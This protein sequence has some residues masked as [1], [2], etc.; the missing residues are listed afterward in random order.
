MKLDKT[1]I[2]IRGMTCAACVRRVERILKSVPGV[3]DAV[4]N[5]ATSKATLSHLSSAIDLNAVSDS[6]EDAGYHFLGIVSNDSEDRAE[7]ARKEDLL[8]IRRKLIVGAILSVFIHL[9]AM[10]HM[11]P[12]SIHINPATSNFIQLLMTT[13]VV[14]WVGGR[15]LG[16]A[17][18]ALRQ[19][20]SDMNTLV[21][22]GA[23]SAYFYSLVVTLFPD[24]LSSGSIQ[25]YVYFDGAAMIVT[26]VLLGRY[27]EARAKGKTS[28]AIRKLIKLKPS[29]A[30]V[31]RN[32]EIVDVPIELL[33]EGDL[34]QVRPGERIPTDGEIVSGQSSVDEAM[35]T[36]ESMPV[37]KNIGDQ[38]YGAT[39]NQNGSLTVRATRVGSETALAKVIRL[40][41][42]AQGSKAPIQRIADRVAAVFV[43]VV[44]VIALITFFIWFYLPSDP[45]ISR[46]MLNFVSVLIIAC[47][48]AMGLATPTAVMVGTGAAAERGILIK[49]GE[50]LEMA[51]KINTV[52]FDKTG[53]LTNGKPTVIDTV[54]TRNYTTT[55]LLKFAAS[56]ESLSEHPLARS[57]CDMASDLGTSLYQVESFESRTGHG[58]TGVVEGSVIHVGSSKLIESLKIDTSNLQGSVDSLE[59]A[60]RTVI[61]VAKDNDLVG[62]LGVSDTLR[63]SSI[64]SIAQLKNMGINVAMITGD[65]RLAA[66]SI[67]HALGIETVLAE[68]LPADKADEIKRLQQT[69]KVVAMVGDG[70]NDAPALS[71]ADIG[72]AVGAG[73][74]VAVEAGSITLMT[75]DLRLVPVAI[76]F[77]AQTMRVIRQ[78]LFWAFFYNTLGIPVAAGVLY[79]FFGILL[80]PVMAAAAMAL[81]SVSVVSNSLRLRT[82]L[83]RM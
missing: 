35:L 58:V 5:L 19:K 41:E 56:L 71:A 40:V 3:D 47:P 39:I 30:R 62:V 4:V 59:R 61:F 31:I 68:V 78:N 43:P 45:S 33:S 18:K 73:S 21:A 28:A 34:F 36:G 17:W 66:D 26:L 82:T 11:L 23:L 79:P 29:S 80:T 76:T 27:L 48:C 77:S 15:F 64:P 24:L 44:L 81:S 37:D 14:F 67:G 49:G 25:P 52:V 20:T 2:Q 53:T 38:V 9:F 74:D 7:K 51:C 55:D 60:G 6:L 83:S 50:T 54:T 1:T 8:D 72:I 10:G 13:P 63:D 42:E 16:G 46:A 65:N 12:L 32:S 57:I 69:G 70:I 75:N 22:L